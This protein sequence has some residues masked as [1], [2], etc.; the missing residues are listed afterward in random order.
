MGITEPGNTR[1]ALRET[2]GLTPGDMELARE[3][4]DIGVH[5]LERVEEEAVEMGAEDGGTLLSGETGDAQADSVTGGMM[6][7]SVMLAALKSQGELREDYDFGD[8][9]GAMQDVADDATI[10]LAR[11]TVADEQ[12]QHTGKA[13]EELDT[14]EQPLQTC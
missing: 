11:R 1:E 14:A 7:A 13:I 6:V 12:A 9:I 2:L 5:T 4:T 3:A 8:L 10:E